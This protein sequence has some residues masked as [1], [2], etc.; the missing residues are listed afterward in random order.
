MDVM[1][2]FFGVT[3]TECLPEWHTWIKLSLPV[4]HFPKRRYE[5]KISLWL[6]TF[7]LFWHIE[8]ALEEHI[9]S[10]PSMSKRFISTFIPQKMEQHS[11]L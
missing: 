6:C 5:W 3:C 10:V 7:W 11:T 8:I 4:L 9:F 1:K 2:G